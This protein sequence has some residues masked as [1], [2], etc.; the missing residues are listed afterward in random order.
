MGLSEQQVSLKLQMHQ[1]AMWHQIWHSIQLCLPFQCHSP[2]SL[3]SPTSQ[4]TGPALLSLLGYLYFAK[5]IV[6]PHLKKISHYKK[7]LKKIRVPV[8]A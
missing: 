3:S 1:Q 7:I 4:R 2:R 8:K 6:I 5:H